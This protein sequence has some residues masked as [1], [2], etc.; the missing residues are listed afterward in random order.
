MSFVR[1]MV[2]KPSFSH[3]ISVVVVVVAELKLLDQGGGRQGYHI[4][5]VIGDCASPQSSMLPPLGV[6]WALSSLLSSLQPGE[7][8]EQ[9]QNK[10]VGL[11]VGDPLTNLPPWGGISGQTL[12]LLHNNNHS[13]LH[14][15]SCSGYKETSVEV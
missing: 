2:D 12:E 6:W 4:Q 8:G 1:E 10:V 9:G 5:D 15:R 3:P 13:N 11:S 14:G 7:G